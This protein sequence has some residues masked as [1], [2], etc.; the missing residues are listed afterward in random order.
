MSTNPEQKVDTP[1]APSE[2]PKAYD[3]NLRAH[4]MAFPDF[5]ACLG[6]LELLE[7]F[8]VLERQLMLHVVQE[9][10][11]Y[12]RENTVSVKG[13]HHPSWGGW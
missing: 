4:G 11:F 1:A 13:L 6:I 8:T 5:K 10:L 9:S 3:D 7:P 2:L 12:S